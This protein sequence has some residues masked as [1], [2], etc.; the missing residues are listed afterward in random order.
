MEEAGEDPTYEHS[1]SLENSQS[2][3]L[4]RDGGLVVCELRG[5]FTKKQVETGISFAF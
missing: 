3:E 2:L 5:P 4:F 1:S